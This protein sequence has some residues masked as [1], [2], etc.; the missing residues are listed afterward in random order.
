MSAATTQPGGAGEGYGRALL[1]RMGWSA[2]TGLGARRDGIVDP[3]TA[4]RKVENLGVG[5]ARARP[6]AD[7]WWDKAMEDAYG[8][9]AS[10][11][12]EALLEACEG[13]RCRPGGDG[14]LARVAE[15]DRLLAGGGARAEPGRVDGEVEEK[16]LRRRRNEARRVRNAEKAE[17]RIQKVRRREKRERK[18]K[19]KK[20]KSW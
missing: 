10:I 12:K 6:F 17:R 4:K 20:E 2:G 8:G 7:A 16:A 5:A 15:A 13:R 19:E 1:Q 18:E 14:K 11:G 9:S 3:V